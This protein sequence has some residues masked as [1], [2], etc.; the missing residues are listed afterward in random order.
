MSNE[1]KILQNTSPYAGRWIALL[2]GRIIAHGGTP[3]QARLAAQKS[4]YK[5]KP[6][7]IYMPSSAPLSFSPLIEQVRI[8]LSDEEVYLV[9]GMLRDAMLGRS[10]H[11]MD[12]AVPNNAIGAARRVAHALQSD[13]YILDEAFDTA[14]VIVTSEENQHDVLDF[15]AYRGADLVSDLRGRD[16]NMNALAFDLRTRSIIDPLNGA[17]DIRLKIIRSCSE[18]AF[19]DDPIRIL[20]AIRFAANLGFKIQ[21]ETRQAMEQ[22]ASFLPKTSTERKRDELFKILEGRKPETALRALEILGIFPFLAPELSGMKGVEQSTPHLKD[23][24]EHTLTV[25]Q[26]LDGILKVLTLG[27]SAEATQDLFTG[28]LTLRLGRYREQLSRHFNMPLN[29]SRSMRA[30]LFFAT[31]YHDVSKPDTKSVDD[32]GRIRFIGHDVKGSMIAVERASNLNLSNAEIDR[33]KSIISNHMRF[34]FFVRN[35]EKEKNEPSRKAIFRFFRDT[36]ESGV[37][38]VLL[39]LADLRGTYDQTLTQ[40]T[41]AAALDV[42]RILLENYWEKPEESVSPKRI[43]DGHD[44]ITEY[45]LE[46]GP[47]VGRL[48]EAVR[49]EQAAGK[50]TSRKEAL[51]FGQKWLADNQK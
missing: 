44:V 9:G 42:A 26:H 14:R 6:E 27:Y 47:L 18:S 4:R 46:S 28:L 12:F 2:Q 22:A 37:D 32:T 25:I 24:W 50:V 51:A 49:E 1:K 13:F 33:L 31:L 20:R 23:V 17:S 38:L 48:L 15:A 34:H 41:W 30:L 21:P 29:A 8:I 36:G 7:I 40:E 43:L 11:D 10:T 3:E 16:F 19:R 45:D 39:G 35:L 5:E